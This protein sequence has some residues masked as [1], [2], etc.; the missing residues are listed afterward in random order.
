M[1]KI[2]FTIFFLSIIF[3]AEYSYSQLTKATIGV[4]GFTCSLC[5]KGVQGQF[6]SLDYVKSVKADLKNTLFILTFKSKP[7]INIKEL[8]SA[9]TDGG[10]SVRNISVVAKGTLKG[11][12]TSGFW[13]SAPNIPDIKLND[14]DESFTDGDKISIEGVVNIKDLS[15]SVTSISKL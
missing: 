14:I 3:S 4:D 12:N 1:K 2:I 7:A 5:A 13:L 9:V 11:N 6:E 8:N 10:F 15:I